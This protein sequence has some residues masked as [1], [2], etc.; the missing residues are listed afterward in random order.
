MKKKVLIINVC[1]EK[2]SYFEFV[3]PIEN[4]VKKSGLRCKVKNYLELKEK[5]LKEVDKII[6]CG[7][8]LKDF[9]YLNH[10]KK[11]EWIKEINKPIFGI[12]AGMQIIS[13]IFALSLVKKTLIGKYKV[14]VI[15][16]KK[17]INKNFYAYFLNSMAIKT[18]KNFDILAKINRVPCLIKHKN[19][20][21]YACLFHPEVYNDE[22]ILNFLNQ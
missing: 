19:K 17:L 14:K 11:F 7:T 9:D 1:K 4:I 2:L 15:K 20:E 22:I 5:D 3:K 21:I 8:A 16:K 12:C 6:I 13:K 10:I 18:N